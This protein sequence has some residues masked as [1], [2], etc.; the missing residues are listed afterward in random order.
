MEEILK[1]LNVCIFCKKMKNCLE[2]Y[3][4]IWKKSQQHYQIIIQQLTYIQ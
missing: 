4:E 2:K 3:N 1:K